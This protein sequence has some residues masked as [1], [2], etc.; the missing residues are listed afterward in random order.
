MI[1]RKNR[2]HGHH[3]VSRVR[4]PSLHGEHVSVRFAGNGRADYRAAV[5]VSKKVDKRAVVR[6]RIRRRLFE[7]LRVECNLSGKPI[8]VIIYAKTVNI[9]TVPHDVLVK[10]VCDLIQKAQSRTPAARA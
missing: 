10:E 7:I 9:A 3:S 5:V 2:F 4:G 1:I 8:D 6:N